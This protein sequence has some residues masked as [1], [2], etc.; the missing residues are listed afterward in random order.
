[1]WAHQLNVALRMRSYGY[2][3]EYFKPK[4]RLNVFIELCATL[5]C[6]VYP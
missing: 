2:S 6:R 3:Q 4:S 5:I 1:M